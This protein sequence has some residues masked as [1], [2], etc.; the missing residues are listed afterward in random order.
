MR[1]SCKYDILFNALQDV[2]GVV[3]D[4]MAD[5]DTQ[6]IIFRFTRDADGV[7]GVRLVGYS[8]TLIYKRDFV[9]NESYS[10]SVEAE[11]IKENGVGYFQIR[12]KDLLGFLG[13]YKSL[14]KTQVKDVIFEIVRDKVKC[15][16]IECPVL[17]AEKQ[18]EIEDNRAFNPDYVDEE[19]EREYISQYMFRLIPM[20]PTII[21]RIEYAPLEDGYHEF[22]DA[23]LKV[24]TE[25]LFKN[26]QNTMGVY[27]TLFFMD[28]H[29][30]IT[31]SGYTTI[32][33]NFIN[34]D[35]SGHIFENIGLPYKALTFIDKVVCRCRF[36]RVAKAENKLFFKLDTGEAC[37]E[38]LTKGFPD[39]SKHRAIFKKDSF[40]AIDKIY[41][42]DVLRRFA[43]SD[44]SIRFCV[45]AADN[46]IS[47]ENDVYSQ[48][49]DFSE[50]QAIDTFENLHFTIMPANANSAL[51]ETEKFMPDE[52]DMYV[53]L[54]RGEKQ[55]VVYVCFADK[56]AMWF[57]ML[58]TKVY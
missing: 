27:G 56:R 44:S 38:V 11:D 46:K 37:M 7:A 22:E 36:F 14:R 53:Y 51:L 12:S 48:D 49:I 39:F 6:N 57:S 19:S 35:E 3:E 43:L 41:F 45:H 21:Q 52:D 28:S 33:H 32:M 40:F 10:I 25:T 13:S 42:R 5:Q 58:K 34:S 23:S 47:V 9:D 55:D 50:S 29:V 17:S 31:T 20:K 26:L 54:C 24:Y 30:G 4:S 8:P 2:A 15:T 1:L 18:Q 16:V